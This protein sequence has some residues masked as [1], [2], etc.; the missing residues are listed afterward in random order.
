MEGIT[1]AP[2]QPLPR[3]DAFKGLLI[4]IIHMLM[5]LRLSGNN[6]RLFPIIILLPQTSKIIQL[7]V[8]IIQLEQHKNKTEIKVTSVIIINDYILTIAYSFS[9]I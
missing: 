3:V 9:S 4:I 6:L 1:A 8:I 5:M 7:Q 2:H